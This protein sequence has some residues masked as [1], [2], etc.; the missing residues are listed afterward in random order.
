MDTL[1]SEILIL[2][3]KEPRITLNELSSRLKRKG[4]DISIEGVR[5]RVS[6]VLKNS[7]FMPFIKWEEYGLSLLT[8]EIKVRGGME[9]RKQVVDNVKKIGSFLNL[10]TFGNFDVIAFFTIKGKSRISSIIDR[11]KE[12]P[13]VKEVSHSM[14]TEQQI[15]LENIFS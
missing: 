4:I 12:I 3:A 15:S 1:D 5:K 14:I 13:R 6:R 7:L 9:A 11:L 2:L 10:F 8:V